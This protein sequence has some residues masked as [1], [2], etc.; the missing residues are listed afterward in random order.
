MTQR[1][2][3]VGTNQTIVIKVGGSVR[4]KGQEGDLLVAET[5]SVGGLVVERR[6]ESEI[7]RARAAVGDHVLFD[8]RL[9]LTSSKKGR[10]GHRSENGWER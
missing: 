4:V 2:I 6:S 5:K 10:G 9:K 1:S 7:G 3:L 8:L